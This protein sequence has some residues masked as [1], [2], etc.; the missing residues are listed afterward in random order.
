MLLKKKPLPA[1]QGKDA[2]RSSEQSSGQSPG[3]R[4][5]GSSIEFSFEM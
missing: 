5:L 3:K 4:N 2:A 1:R